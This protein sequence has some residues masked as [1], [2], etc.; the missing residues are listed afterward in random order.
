MYSDNMSLQG[1]P[2]CGFVFTKITRI[3]DTF[4]FGSVVTSHPELTVINSITSRTRNWRLLSFLFLLLSCCLRVNFHYVTVSSVLPGRAVLTL[5]AVILD[6]LMDCIDMLTQ[7][8]LCGGSVLALTTGMT[9]SFVFALS[10]GLQILPPL[11]LEATILTE[12]PLPSVL[13]PP[14]LSHSLLVF[15]DC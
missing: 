2:S 10:V 12:E 1:P 13:C 6:A 7:A 4:M 11:G 8:L 9:H 3:A 15:E 14:V 5:I